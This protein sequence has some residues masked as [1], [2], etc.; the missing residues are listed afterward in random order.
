MARMA[1]PAIL[2]QA[3]HRMWLADGGWRRRTQMLSSELEFLARR[4]ERAAADARAARWRRDP[5]LAWAANALPPWRSHWSFRDW[6]GRLGP[7]RGRRAVEPAPSLPALV[8]VDGA[9]AA[10]EPEEDRAA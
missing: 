6:L 4:A 10:I 8:A 2:G 9:A 1:A 5:E 7:A 3:R